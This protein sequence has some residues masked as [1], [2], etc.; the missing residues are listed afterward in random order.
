MSEQSNDLDALRRENELLRERLAHSQSGLE[1]YRRAVHEHFAKSYNPLPYTDEEIQELISSPR[2][3][4][5]LEVIEE[6]ER[7]LK[8]A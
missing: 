2:G 4:P 8:G 5:L 3:Q 1:I 7:E 6:Y